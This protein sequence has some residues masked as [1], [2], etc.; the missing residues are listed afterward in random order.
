MRERHGIM[1][2]TASLTREA[3][4]NM[5]ET[6]AAPRIGFKSAAR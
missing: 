2:A 4:Q 5:H 3:S 6:I 1:H